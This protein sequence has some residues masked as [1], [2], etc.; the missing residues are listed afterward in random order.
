MKLFLKKA[1]LIGLLVMFAS[2]GKV[3]ATILSINDDYLTA[4]IDT[5]YGVISLEVDEPTRG[6]PLEQLGR[7][8]FWYRTQDSS[9][10]HRVD[11]L[12]LTSITTSDMHVEL[13]YVDPDLLQIDLIYAVLDRNDGHL[14]HSFVSVQNLGNTDLSVDLFSYSDFNLSGQSGFDMVIPAPTT[15][16]Y[17]LMQCDNQ[18]L[19]CNVRL[20]NRS[21]LASSLEVGNAMDLLNRLED[22]VLDDFSG[23]DSLGGG[24]PAWVR[25]YQASLTA[26]DG[27]A[28]GSDKM[29]ANEVFRIPEPSSL[30]LL[31]MGL[32]GLGLSGSRKN[33]KA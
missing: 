19:I 10:E 33:T 31:G 30:A 29:G 4:V 6:V 5:S 13:T 14:F 24:D 18:P 22:S 17:E 25:Q 28:G 26:Y 16:F 2:I 7:Q 3:N 15:S 32:L 27:Q 12:E 23:F 8:W 1:F 11:S 20:E 21:D 9:Q